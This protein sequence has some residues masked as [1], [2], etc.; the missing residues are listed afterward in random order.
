MTRTRKHRCS[1]HPIGAL[2]TVDALA[3]EYGAPADML[4]VHYRVTDE[5]TTTVSIE[6]IGGGE[7]IRITP[8]ALVR[9]T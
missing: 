6:P 7:E 3:V 4:G 5:H 9:V 2:V 1:P 8:I